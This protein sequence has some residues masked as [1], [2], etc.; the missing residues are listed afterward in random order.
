MEL[1]NT[2]G[3]PAKTLDQEQADE[4]SVTTEYFE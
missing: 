2:G 3:R 4:D 1:V